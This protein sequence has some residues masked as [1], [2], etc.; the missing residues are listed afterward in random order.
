MK[1]GSKIGIA[2]AVILALAGMTGCNSTS[3]KNDDA[4]SRVN[5]RELLPGGQKLHR[6]AREVEIES[7]PQS[8]KIRQIYRD[9]IQN[10]QKP[11]HSVP[12]LQTKPFSA[13]HTTK[14]F[15]LNFHL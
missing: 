12:W 6:N 8:K 7:E 3:Q 2:A 10:E 11:C 15:Q 14:P 9:N 5:Q 13:C 4:D 1:K